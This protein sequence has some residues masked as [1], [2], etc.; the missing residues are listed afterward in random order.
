MP[1]TVEQHSEPRH[2]R[3]VLNG[4][5]MPDELGVAA[6]ALL[7]IVRDL[8]LPHVLVDARALVGGHGTLDLYAMA[9][10]LSRDPV[11]RTVREAVLLP[12]IASMSDDVRFWETACVNRGLKVKVFSEPE[13]A[14]TW[15]FADPGR[16]AGPVPDG[17]AS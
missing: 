6:T 17:L 16:A 4:I 11:A 3:L 13:P 1:A 14:L 5:V 9:E 2:I 7:E 10:A 12:E 8:G 15:L